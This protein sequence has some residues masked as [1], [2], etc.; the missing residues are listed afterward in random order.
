MNSPG[1][2]L[3]EPDFEAPVAKPVRQ[4][5][6][7]ARWLR[8]RLR[9]AV[10]TLATPPLIL[11]YHRIACSSADPWKLC[12]SPRN[13]REQMD[14]VAR[15]RPMPLR[16]LVAR[17]RAGRSVRG[18]IVVTFD[19]GYRDNLDV[20]LPV[21]ERN[22]V[23]ATLFCTAGYVGRDEPFWWDALAAM[24]LMPGRL[25]D[26]LVLHAGG[27]TVRWALEAAVE[28]TA[29]SRAA[30]RRRR[31]GADPA[32]ARLRF[33]DA[34]WRWLRA[35]DEGERLQ[36]LAAIAAWT[37]V[38]Y[39]PEAAAYPLSQAQLRAL[40]RNPLIEIG[41][42]TLTHPTLSIL[43]PSRQRHEIAHGKAVLEE[44][45]GRPVRSFAYPFG[46]LDALTPALV[47]AAGFESACTTDGRAARRPKDVLRLPR[48]TVGD[49]DGDTFSRELSGARR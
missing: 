8:A 36:L 33:H 44:V 37:D 21:L 48:M 46:D 2:W 22:G 14:V 27:C 47:A 25:P 10:D 24:L 12:V 4:A 31:S 9:R 40:A 6:A 1:G 11:M 28:Y 29:A 18:A 39:R 35:L 32:S 17:L 26:T 23:P 45:I 13:F 43:P 19:D 7:A 16:D 3:P 20:A 30:D 49:W 5:R 15:L 34:L 42:H 41:A 38:Q